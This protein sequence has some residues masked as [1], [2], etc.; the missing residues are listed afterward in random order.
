MRKHGYFDA[1][2]KPAFM[3]LSACETDLS[4]DPRCSDRPHH[5]KNAERWLHKALASEQIDYQLF[6]ALMEPTPVVTKTERQATPP[7][8]RAPS[9][10]KGRSDQ[11]GYQRILER[12]N[13]SLRDRLRLQAD[14]LDE[15]KSAKRKL[16]NEVARERDL[17]RI[18][19][20]KV[21]TLE[22]ELETSRRMASYAIAGQRRE[23]DARRKAE[24]R[25][26]RDTEARISMECQLR[27][28][29]AE[30]MQYADLT[31]DYSDWSP[32]PSFDV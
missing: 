17:G 3:I 10:S 6:P 18:F 8:R 26:D 25:A 14:R 15:V 11:A 12:E 32:H 24:A 29:Q 21:H 19:E 16:E 22:Q 2:L 31:E 4:R 23:N 9:V 27:R 13:E 28:S 7:P 5:A 30:H 1:D 20:K